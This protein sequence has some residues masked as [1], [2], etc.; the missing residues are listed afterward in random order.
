MESIAIIGLSF[1][2]P[3]GAKDEDGLWSILE[4][5]QNVA[6]EWPEERGKIDGHYDSDLSKDNKLYAKEAHF[7]RDDPAAFDAPFFLITEK[8]ATSM[9]PQQRLLLETSYR[10]LENA[11]IPA[12]KAAGSRTSVFTATMADDYSRILSKDPD[13][14]P[15]TSITGI[16]PS[17]LANRLSWY[18][19]L[20]GPSVHIN[21]AC[22]SSMVAMDLACQNLRNRQ[23]NMAMVAG[24]NLIIS[25]E[26][27]L[28]LSNMNFLSP[29]GRCYSFDSRANG[30]ARGEGAV[31]LILKSFS[32]AIRDNDT[33]RAV[34]RGTASNQ[35]GHTPGITQPSAAAQEDL[36]RKLY[37]ECGLSFQD[38]RYVEAHGTGTAIGDPIEAKAIGKIF[39][40]SR[41]TRDPLYIGSIKSNI[42]HIEGASG[43]AGIVKAIMILEKGII[44]PQALFQKINPAIKTNFWNLCVP[45]ECKPWPTNGLRRISVN[46]FGFG[47]SNSHIILDDAYHSLQALGVSSNHCTVIEGAHSPSGCGNIQGQPHN[48]LESDGSSGKTNGHET[49]SNAKVAEE[50][51][52]K[53]ITNGYLQNENSNGKTNGHHVLEESTT[54]LTPNEMAELKKSQ[55]AVMSQALSGMEVKTES[56]HTSLPY[57]LLIWSAR[58]KAALERMVDTYDVFYATA[59][60]SHDT[61]D[62]LAR[63][64]T[65]R[66]S[67]MLWRSCALVNTESSLGEKD[68][69]SLSLAHNQRSSSQPTAAFVFTGQGAQY[70]KMGLALL[71]YPVFRTTIHAIGDAF[72]SQGAEWDLL[73]ALENAENIIKPEYSQPLCT[74]IQLGLVELLKSFGVSPTAVVGHSSGEIAAAYAAGALSLE[75]C[76]KVAYHRGSLA[77]KLVQYNSITPSAMISVNLSEKEAQDYL[78]SN[79]ATTQNLYVACINSPGNVTMSGSELSINTLKEYCDTN[80]IFN[81]KLKTGLAYHTPLM[82]QMSQE[83]LDA[84]GDDLLEEN[85]TQKRPVVMI[86]TVT[87]ASVALTALRHPSYWVQ[88]LVSPVRFVDSLQYLAQVAPTEELGGKSITDV[89]EIG[90]HGALQR[91]VKDTLSSIRYISV[92]SKFENALEATMRAAGLL[93]TIGFPVDVNTVNQLSHKKDGYV[94]YLTHL[95]EYPFDKSQT[96]WYES[97]FSRDYR[98]R[99]PT[100]DVLGTRAYDWNPLEPK[101]RKILSLE[102]IPWISDH[103]VGDT[104]LYPGA[105]TLMMAVEAAKQYATKISS[106]PQQ[107]T[108]FLVK[109]AEFISP[110]VVR[111]GFEGRAE[112][113]ISLRP[114]QWSYEKVSSRSE[115]RIWSQIN[116]QWTECFRA[117]IHT[118]YEDAYVPIDNGHEAKAQNASHVQRWRQAEDTCLERIGRNQL[119]DYFDSHGAQ[120]GKSFAL[121]DEVLWDGGDLCIATVPVTSPSQ[122]YSG[123]VH[124]AVLDAV[125]QTCAVAPSNGLKSYMNTM[126]PHKIFDMWL[127]PSGWQYPKTTQ[128][129]MLSNTKLKPSASGLLCSLTV[130]SDDDKPLCYAKLME[131]SSMHSTNSGSKSENKKLLYNVDWKPQL[132]ML[133]SQ[134]LNQLCL[135]DVFEKDESAVVEYRTELDATLVAVIKD[136]LHALRDFDTSQAAP[137]FQK[138]IGW[139]QRHSQRRTKPISLGSLTE[140]IDHVEKMRPSWRLFSAIAHDLLA[141]IRGEKDALQVL[142]SSGL[143]EE[144]YADVFANSCN[145]KMSTFI[146]LSAH[147]KPTQRILEVGAGT[148]GMTSHILSALQEREKQTGGQAF[149]EY[150]YTDISAAFFEKA[151]ERFSGFADRMIFKL[152]D[153]EKTITEQGFEG[154]TYDMVVA[155]SVLHATS[156]LQSTM[157]SLRRMLK[158]GGKLVILE[159]TADPFVVSFGFGIVPG[160]WASKEE[161]RAWSACID[162]RQ[163]DQVLRESGYSGNDLV[164]HDYKSAEAH[165]VSII[166]STAVPEAAVAQQ[167]SR[168]IF[169]VADN[170][171][172]QRKLANATQE[173]FSQ[174]LYRCVV[175]TLPKLQDVPAEANDR[176][177]VLADLGRSLLSSIS[178]ASFQQLQTTVKTWR[179]ILWVSSADI[180]DSSYPFSGV[181]NGLLRSLRSEEISRRVYSLILEL[182]PENISQVT[183]HIHTVFEAAFQQNSPE[184]EYVVRDGM[185]QIGRI[186]AEKEANIDMQSAIEP[187]IVQENWLPSPP[188]KFAVGTPGS[189]ETLQFVEDHDVATNLEPTEIEIEAKAWGVAFRDV[190]IALGRLDENDFGADCA[191]IV[192]RVGSECT[193]LRPGDRVCVNA[194]GCLKMFVRCN[195]WGA[196]KIPDGLSFQEATSIL[197]PCIT[198]WYSLMDIARLQKGDK[199]LI[200]AASG[201]TGQMAIQI[202]Q[203]AGAEVFATVGYEDKKELL[204]REFGIKPERIF[205]SRN[206]S[207]AKGIMRVT[208]GYGVDVVLNSLAGEGLRA[209]WEC[210]APYGRFIELG[211]AD[212]NANSA[213]PM[214]CFAKNVSFSA[215]DLHHVGNHRADLS[216]R[217]LDKARE[218]MS[219]QVIRS[220]VPLHDYPVSQIEE[221]FRYFQSGKNTGRV[222]IS[223][224]SEDVVTKKLLKRRDWTFDAESSYVIAGGFGG[225]GRAL[226]K[227]MAGKGAKNILI[228]SRSGVSTK[229][230]ADA[231]Q[232]LKNQGVT[233]CAPKC[234]ATS[235]EAVSRALC[236]AAQS[237]IP[238]VRGAIIAA[239]VLQDAVFENMTHDQWKLAVETK[240]QSSWNLHNLLPS[241]LDFFI[242]LS[243]LAGIYGNVAQSN[244]AAACTFQDALS[245]HRIA[246]GR[247]ALSLDLGW[248]SA[249]GIIAETEEYQK[250]RAVQAD[251]GRI[252][253]DEFLSL[254][255]IYC[256]PAL[257]VANIEKS[258]L[259]VG[260]LTPADLLAQGLESP[261]VLTRPLFYT[262]SQVRG[263]AQGALGINGINF[264]ALFRQAETADARAEVVVSALA[265]KLARALSMPA[266]DVN[267]DKPL[268]VFGVDSLVAVELRNWIGK[269]FE[270]DIP[271]FDLMNGGTVKAIGQTIAR[272]TTFKKSN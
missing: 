56:E 196:A 176:L 264:A 60:P 188:L 253:T 86:S 95:P 183:S 55:L 261:E 269:E 138:Y 170:D 97:R 39:R 35:D 59:R 204:I 238:P 233:V 73:H 68:F 244:Y 184:L 92:L 37:Q 217:L 7:I 218:L 163:W 107:V 153:L 224:K 213:L 191:G 187:I 202:A 3:A 133:S 168:V 232:E 42:G 78:R 45:T 23:S 79:A 6:S 156:D 34:I 116:G 256:D 229:T 96:H 64:L 16:E 145:H 243:S 132:S 1:K 123:L 265:H 175:T 166:A 61:L 93:W 117:V 192:T 271:I 4:N 10:A 198:A 25:P 118:E 223:A 89:I 106:M 90:P 113:V 85:K 127:S 65:D 262:F 173:A 52:Q 212:I 22:S 30:Y 44:P 211:K 137:H 126:V 47:G 77:G 242:Q 112:V 26:G 8:E 237:G 195:E 49:N 72:R 12:E 249:I 190:F 84:M 125:F 15:R 76:A 180:Q 219:T 32:D 5:G 255:S 108:G 120:Y 266:E 216:R 62:A 9:D 162:E 270:A 251:M 33:I 18:Y 227:W 100:P 146:D 57:R 225:I 119:Y 51:V 136:T 98:L 147:E 134:Q 29:D 197:G 203:M 193:N 161:Y 250:N 236:E 128:N 87:G 21:T 110:I 88:N 91:S 248:M 167:G 169:V 254:M 20:R 160:W 149:S 210:V 114:L 124:P 141:I 159:I 19:D 172:M 154:G 171:E 206:N 155:G 41:S 94:R 17:M 241:D 239:M 63:T 40:S 27:P 131:M 53:P 101:W 165:S 164:L 268:S 194:M 28:L 158:P 179:N 205:Y 121:L 186:I 199:I 135:S 142:F 139:M 80:S 157:M 81:Q 252:E 200:H 272:K 46:S 152:L 245:R 36:I 99:D 129:R 230:A 226:I 11:G 71:S 181:A 151:K 140:Q 105:G 54:I 231:V 177:V 208:N 82:E 263:I 75:S 24:C 102:D 189:L 14:T 50:Q 104:T 58:D 267:V 103:V 235:K 122:Q 221:A 38:T 43:L 178:P 246:Q 214:S 31:V 174:N 66:R 83:Y 182:S 209:S 74:A 247:K 260:A 150:V 111:P 257:P 215:I 144:F 70:A 240:V 148:G 222:I 143:A 234:D 201:G 259:F 130:L 67:V 115:V 2:L 220:P 109:E 48:G 207:F 258:Q 69:S 228:L 13:T 185:V